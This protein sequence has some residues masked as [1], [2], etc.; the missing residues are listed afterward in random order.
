MTILSMGPSAA[1][2]AAEA[3]C[4][5]LLQM[6]CHTNDVGRK[7]GFVGASC[8]GLQCTALS[9]EEY[10]VNALLS[11]SLYLVCREMILSG[12]KTWL[13]LLVLKCCLALP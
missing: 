12:S 2:R 7:I 1:L 4:M 6:V 5:T 10:R 8:S 9:V 13:F 3:S 11:Y